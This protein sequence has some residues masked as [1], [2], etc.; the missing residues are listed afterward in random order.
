ML[1]GKNTKEDIFHGEVGPATAQTAP[2]KDNPLNESDL[3]LILSGNSTETQANSNSK[4][5]AEQSH[6]KQEDNSSDVLSALELILK[7]EAEKFAENQVWYDKHK[8]TA[9][10]LV[11][12]HYDR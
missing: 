7:T 9:G 5:I 12:W 3:L 6:Q 1:T 11:C 4:P 2:L 10:K 8:K